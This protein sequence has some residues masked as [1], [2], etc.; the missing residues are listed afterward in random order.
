MSETAT[1]IL[2][3]DNDDRLKD[4]LS[5]ILTAGTCSGEIIGPILGGFLVEFTSYH[6]A[7]ISLFTFGLMLMCI[8]YHTF[9][10]YKY[11]DYN[12]PSSQDTTENDIRYYK[13]R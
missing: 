3:W 5:G 13:N 7:Y 9:Y 2:G 6:T 4:A 10:I 11:H 8:Y 12:L 1:N